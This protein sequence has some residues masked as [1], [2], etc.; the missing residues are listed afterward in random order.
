MGEHPAGPFIYQ[1]FSIVNR[2]WEEPKF[3]YISEPETLKNAV[4]QGI[5]TRVWSLSRR[6]PTLFTT[7]VAGIALVKLVGYVLQKTKDWDTEYDNPKFTISWDDV[8]V[9]IAVTTWS[10]SKEVNPPR[11]DPATVESNTAST[12]AVDQ[13]AIERREDIPDDK[14]LAI[15]VSSHGEIEVQCTP[16]AEPPIGLRKVFELFAAMMSKIWG[17]ETNGLAWLEMPSSSLLVDSVP[18]VYMKLVLDGPLL[19]LVPI[20][21]GDFADGLMQILQYAIDKETWYSIRS[22][23]AKNSMHFATVTYGLNARP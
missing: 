6:V 3:R 1:L 11:N 16:Q 4:Y 7:P 22:T 15:E 10:G 21:W 19:D 13:T 20:F 17:H 5:E 2:Y 8:S 18:G 23:F 14:T 12:L 9:G